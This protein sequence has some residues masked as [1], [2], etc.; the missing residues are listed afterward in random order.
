MNKKIKNFK[1]TINHPGG[2]VQ[3]NREIVDNWE[4]EE[5]EPSESSKHKSKAS[6]R[7]IKD[8]ND[9]AKPAKLNKSNLLKGFNDSF[10]E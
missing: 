5:Q 8:I 1:D 2:F 4:Y 6:K 10:T 7:S 3:L 9:E